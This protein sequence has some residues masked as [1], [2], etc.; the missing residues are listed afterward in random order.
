VQLFDDYQGKDRRKRR[1]E[2]TDHE[3]AAANDEQEPEEAML[4]EAES[5]AMRALGLPVA[6][7]S[8]KVEKN[9]R[10][11][12]ARAGNR[13]YQRVTR[14]KTVAFTYNHQGE[15][16]IVVRNEPASSDNTDTAA[17]LAEA[18]PSQCGWCRRF[19]DDYAASIAATAA[20]ADA[21]TTEQVIEGW[22]A[23]YNSREDVRREVPAA[24][25]AHQASLPPAEPAEAHWNAV[26]TFH[27]RW[28]VAGTQEEPELGAASVAEP[29]PEGEHGKG[30]AEWRCMR[31]GQE[32]H[33]HK[34]NCFLCGA[35][36][37]PRPS[38]TLPSKTRA[39][40][41]E[42][43][44]E[45]LLGLG[46][47]D[48][49]G[50]SGSLRAEDEEEEEEEV[51]EVR[52]TSAGS[53]RKRDRNW[54]AQKYW[55]Q[56]HRLFSRFDEGIQAPTPPHCS[57][58]LTPTPTAGIQLDHESW[59]SV[60]PEAIADHIATTV[61]ECA[62][63]RGL[64][65]VDAFCGSGGNSIGFA[66]GGGSTHVISIDIDPIKIAAARHNAAIYGV[67]D[68]IEFICGDFFSLIPRLKADLLFL[69]P[70]WGGPSYLNAP[71]F[72]LSMIDIGNRDGTELFRLGMSVAENLV[73]FLPRNTP[74]AELAGLR[75]EGPEGEECVYVERHHLNGKLKTLAAYYGDL[76]DGEGE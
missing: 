55:D 8:D 12:A 21:C 52:E 63:A 9:K 6:F 73:Y 45:A 28:H 76:F 18:A 16:T 40:T 47:A 30:G 61:V 64:T 26:W 62:G 59:F 68:R 27:S 2:A 50:D 44:S 19:A 13:G 39:E 35:A 29:E 14:G 38:K 69:S 10:L 41:P 42:D 65:I 53:A 56:R 31:C 66:R 5:E 72:M 37:R 36:R 57:A 23:F 34:P 33:G 46:H 70:P 4:D 25:R 60:T 32:C 48:G 67:Q 51:E 71:E 7:H 15:A 24:W 43:L 22:D 54:V 17:V 1:G 58:L 74:L 75:E 3:T 49:E 11:D 20:A